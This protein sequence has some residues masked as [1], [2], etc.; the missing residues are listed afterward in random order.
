MDYVFLATGSEGVIRFGNAPLQSCDFEK[1]LEDTAANK[2]EDFYKKLKLDIS[3]RDLRMYISEESLSGRRIVKEIK[4]NH[5]T[6]TV[7]LDELSLLEKQKNNGNYK[8][9][10]SNYDHTRTEK[11]QGKHNHRYI[12]NNEILTSDVIIS[13]PKLKTHE[14]VGITVGLKGFVG[15]VGHKDCLAHH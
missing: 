14:K 1:V 4:E 6:T 2:V 3:S 10:V 11:L 9:R 5:H 12:I 13:V 7:N 15:I 8:Y